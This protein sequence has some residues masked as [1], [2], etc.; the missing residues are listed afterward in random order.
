MRKYRLWWKIDC[1]DCHASNKPVIEDKNHPGWLTHDCIDTY[2]NSRIVTKRVF[3]KCVKHQ[4]GH[5]NN[6]SCI[7]DNC[8]GICVIGKAVA[9]V[10]IL[11]DT[12]Y[13]SHVY[14]TNQ[15]F[16]FFDNMETMEK[17]LGIKK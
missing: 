6:T 1:N 7:A 3:G 2:G 16:D 11:D 5:V 15:Y 17:Y 14:I 9:P 4:S 8:D 12:S 13:D 10:Q